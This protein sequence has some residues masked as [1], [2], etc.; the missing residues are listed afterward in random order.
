SA[1]QGVEQSRLPDI[2]ESDDAGAQ[3]KSG[4][5]YRSDLRCVGARVARSPPRTSGGDRG[6]PAR[7]SGLVDPHDGGA[8]PRAARRGDRHRHRAFDFLLFAAVTSSDLPIPRVWVDTDIALCAY[9]G[10]VDDGFALAALAA[11]HRAGRIELLSV[12][13]VFGN[14]TAARSA[15]C[16]RELLRR[17]GVDV[18]IWRG[19]EA[20]GEET[21]AA[22]AI[23]AAVADNNM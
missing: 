4:R 6:P 10:D 22:E 8:R 12:S 17:A 2:G 5:V 7:R 15:E 11:A 20:P 18:P 13:T 1:G 3:H 16:A 14:S 19:A 23:A 21:D 9:H